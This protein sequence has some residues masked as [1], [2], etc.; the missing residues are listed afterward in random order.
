MGTDQSVGEYAIL[1]LLW[2]DTD[3]SQYLFKDVYLIKQEMKQ[4]DRNKTLY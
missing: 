2:Q 3:I 1:S 4:A